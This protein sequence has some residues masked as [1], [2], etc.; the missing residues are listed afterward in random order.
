MLAAS[1]GFSEYDPQQV[2]FGQGGGGKRSRV[3]R[4]DERGSK[5]VET[6][7]AECTVAE[8]RQHVRHGHESEQHFRLCLTK[9]ECSTLELAEC[10]CADGVAVS[11]GIEMSPYRGAEYNGRS[12]KVPFD[13]SCDETKPPSPVSSLASGDSRITALSSAYTNNRMSTESLPDPDF[14]SAHGHL[15]PITRWHA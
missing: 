11:A 4:I 6:H 14:T 5:A 1:G 2:Y 13:Q 3:R 15:V 7:M 9:W 12:R 10:R 8:R